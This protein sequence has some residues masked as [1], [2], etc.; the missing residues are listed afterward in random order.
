MAR[1]AFLYDD[2]ADVAPSS[3][4]AS[5]T[6]LEALVTVL[7]D[8]AERNGEL[9]Q[10][11]P[12]GHRDAAKWWV[13]LMPDRKQGEHERK[14][15]LGCT[16]PYTSRLKATLACFIGLPDVQARRSVLALMEGGIEYRGDSLEDMMRI[17][18]ER[19]KMREMGRDEYIR[20]V[21]E[22]AGLR[23]GQAHDRLSDA[24]G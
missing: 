23:R 15:A 19:E 8:Y 24:G 22:A 17:Y 12:L 6:P 21:S 9:P 16:D 4:G 10:P 5:T 14:S 13:G 20:Q 18:D 2:A 1:K 11:M 7:T 3:T